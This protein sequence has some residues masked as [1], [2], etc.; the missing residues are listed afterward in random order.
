MTRGLC[1]ALHDVAPATWPQCAQ[2]LAMLDEIGASP[3]T[4]LIVPDFHGLCC[5]EH[6][7]AF[8]ESIE[9]RIRR[10]DEV[11]LHG[12]IH[13]DDAASPRNPWQ[14][15]RRRILTANE[16]EFS[17]LEYTDAKQRIRRGMALMSRLNWKMD[18]FV[19]PA[20]LASADTA[21]ALAET[22]LRYTSTHTALVDLRGRSISAP[23]ITA[24]SRSS[25]RRA[26]SRMWMRAIALATRNAP[27]LRVGLH[28]DDANHP[29]M[30]RAWRKLL[31]E[32][33]NDR[34]PIT[35]I[36]AVAM[37]SSAVADVTG[38]NVAGKS[39]SEI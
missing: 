6:D 3:V 9:Q 29:A 16:G 20:W 23:C 18:G 37:A 33:L 31:V 21:K 10:G 8:V 2:L 36:A 14:W 5:I 28:P 24:S 25:L 35:K 19:P 4:L 26:V 1:V 17:A 12:Y 34:R 11:A 22:T 32:L 7:A 27:L 13:R 39:R 15:F 38:L 30:M